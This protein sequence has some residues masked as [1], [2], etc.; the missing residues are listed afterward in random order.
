MAFAYRVL[1]SKVHET[2]FIRGSGANAFYFH[3]LVLQKSTL[4]YI[5]IYIY[6]RG[7]P[8][9]QV[10]LYLASRG[11]LGGRARTWTTIEI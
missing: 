7:H 6:I 9:V 3:D 4:I 5:Y 1:S 8:Y 2:R 10:P 11:E